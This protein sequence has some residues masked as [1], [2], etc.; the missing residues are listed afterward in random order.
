M[1]AETWAQVAW[2]P[3]LREAK[4]P[5]AERC[6][7]PVARVAGQP[8][9]PEGVA[10]RGIESKLSG[11]PFAYAMPAKATWAPGASADDGVGDSLSQLRSAR[12]EGVGTTARLGRSLFS[13]RFFA[14]VPLFMALSNGRSCFRREGP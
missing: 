3:A 10:E 8:G 13:G 9:V 1:Q 4:L 5:R 7:D 14:R 12:C 11:N 2:T 6:R